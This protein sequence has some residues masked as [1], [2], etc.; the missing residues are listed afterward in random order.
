MCCAHVLF[1]WE[2]YRVASVWRCPVYIH[3]VLGWRDDDSATLYGYV[4]FGNCCRPH[5]PDDFIETYRSHM[6]EI[7]TTSYFGCQFDDLSRNQLG[8]VRADQMW[9]M[10]LY[11]K[12]RTAGFQALNILGV[13]SD[14]P[15]ADPLCRLSIALGE[16][17]LPCTM[18]SVLSLLSVGDFKSLLAWK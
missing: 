10:C 1:Y 18:C 4:T 15:G 12:R 7:V 13:V 9:F 5:F 11:M 16:E 6:V 3:T 17:S 14:R 2:Y 8:H